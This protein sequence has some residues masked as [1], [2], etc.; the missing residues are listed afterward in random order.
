MWILLSRQRP[1]FVALRKPGATSPVP[2]LVRFLIFTTFR[3]LVLGRSTR[4]FGYG[5][6]RFSLPRG[7]K[8]SRRK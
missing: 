7:S 2:V 1:A 5:R 6:P 8:R 4:N 3:P